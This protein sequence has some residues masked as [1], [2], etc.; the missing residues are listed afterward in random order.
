MNELQV[1]ET[2]RGF[3]IR[4]HGDQYLR[5]ICATC[6]EGDAKTYYNL[7]KIVAKELDRRPTKINLGLVTGHPCIIDHENVVAATGAEY[8]ENLRK[9]DY[10]YVIES[11]K[12]SIDKL[13]IEALVMSNPVQ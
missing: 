13:W 10:A 11:F 2:Y 1:L 7:S 9:V 6:A 3:Q 8:F 4:T 5:T 12:K